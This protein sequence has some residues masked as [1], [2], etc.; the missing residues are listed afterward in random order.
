MQAKTVSW[1]DIRQ[2]VLDNP[3]VQAEYEALEEEFK[4]ARQIISLRKASGLSQREFATLLGMKQPQLARI[5]SGKQSPKLETIVKLAA[6]AGY[7]V[8]LH[9]VAPKN[10]KKLKIDPVVISTKSHI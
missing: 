10:Q 3:E 6:G 5:E 2:Q 7:K 8:E 9:F 1:D 4:L